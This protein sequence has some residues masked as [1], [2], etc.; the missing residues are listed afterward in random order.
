MKLV[1]I[2]GGSRGL[3]AALCQQYAKAGF[4]LIEFS[5]SAPHPFSVAC[6]FAEPLQVARKVAENLRPLASTAGLEEVV[7]ISNAAMLSPMGPVSRNDPAAVQA[8]LNANF[9]AAILFMSE[10]IRAFQETPAR[11]TVVSLSSGAATKGYAGWSL[12]CAAK[13]GLDNFMRALALE[14]TSEAHPVYALIIDP[15]IMDTGMQA[16]IRASSPADFPTV[17]RF[18]GLHRDGALRQPAQIAS[19]IR[20]IV[21]EA[22]TGGERF[23]AAEFV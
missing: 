20:R 12:Y 1:V 19:A 16:D 13:A 21:A 2:S 10:A 3:G 5:R 22:Q 15:G 6:D 7:I 9:T 23:V 14:Q 11:K 4:A 8:N 17:E 18:H